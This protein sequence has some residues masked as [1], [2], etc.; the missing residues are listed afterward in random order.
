[1]TGPLNALVETLAVRPTPAAYAAAAREIESRSGELQPVR[2]AILSSH[3]ID[4]IVPYLKVEAARHELY[5][6]HY[7]GGFNAVQQEL[8][9]ASSGCVGF[10]PDV[11]FVAQ[12]LCDVCPPLASDFLRLGSDEVEQLIDETVADYVAAI[13]AFRQHSSAAIIVHNFTA[14]R[15]AALGVYDIMAEH[16]ETAAVRRLNARM[17]EALAAVAGVSVLDYDGLA[18]H[19]GYRH[20]YDD[21]LWHLA[22]IPLTSA[23]LL[24]LAR[25]QAVCLQALFGRRRK[26]LAL[27][28]DNTLWGDVLGEVGAA[29]IQLGQTYPG[30]VYRSFQEYLLRLHRRGVLLAIVSKNNPGEVEEVLNGHPGMVLKPEHFASQRV[31]WR[32]KPQ[33]LAEIAE[34]LSIATDS[35]V[36]FDDQAA[37][38]ELMRQTLPE[39]LTIVAP[40]EALQFADAIETSGAFERLSVTSEDRER[41]RMYRRRAIGQREARLGS[42]DEFLRGLNMSA[43]VR[44]TDAFAFPRVLDLLAKTNQFNVTTRRYSADQLRAT[45]DD[46]RCGVF[47]LHLTDRLGDN[48]IVGV[49]IVRIDEQTAQIESFLLSCRVIGRTAE[50]ALL[51]FVT[52]WARRR[53]ATAVEGEFRPTPK[54]APAADFYMRHGFASVPQPGSASR[55]RLTSESPVPWPPYIQ[56]TET[57][58]V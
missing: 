1:M 35:F 30:N 43:S 57:A 17:A 6:D 39:V 14:P 45:I 58:T 23:G 21:R 12:L 56:I 8:R 18:A 4:P 9:G 22:R 11:V 2:V 52:D 46:P 50:T 31:N 26:C 41:G 34:E 15:A 42:L 37:E 49:A 53:G 25:R 40:S 32:P 29:G 27:D 5:A 10:R 48:G 3:T 20:W 28:L 13:A 47:H 38:C 16:S 55:W 24:A 54:N 19:V 33:N 7:V 44:P 36:F 51:S